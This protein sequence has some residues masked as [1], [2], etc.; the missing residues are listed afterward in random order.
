LRAELLAGSRAKERIR[1]MVII[2][3]MGEEVLKSEEG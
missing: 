1:R 3:M 2:E